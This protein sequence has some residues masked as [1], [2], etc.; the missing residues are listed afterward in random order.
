M[1]RIVESFGCCFLR[2]SLYSVILWLR[3]LSVSARI[4]DHR[5][6]VSMENSHST[7]PLAS[8]V[9]IYFSLSN[10]KSQQGLVTQKGCTLSFTVG[11]HEASVSG[12]G[13]FHRFFSEFSR[14]CNLLIQRIVTMVRNLFTSF[15]FFGSIDWKIPRR[16]AMY[17]LTLWEELML[18]TQ[19]EY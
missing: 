11:F 13:E 1:L 5:W 7:F 19:Y 2:V 6:A 16:S 9:F 4:Q 18:K 17:S 15:Q 12:K 8:R 10:S 3:V 14:D